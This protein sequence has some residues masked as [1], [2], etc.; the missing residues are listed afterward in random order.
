MQDNQS[1]ASF[2][3]FKIYLLTKALATEYSDEITKSLDQIPLV[4]KHIKENLLSD[5]KGEKMLHGKWQHSLIA[6][7]DNEIFAGVVIGSE[8]EK[9]NN[10]WYSKNSIYINDFAVSPKFQKLGLGKFLIKAWVAYN[11]SVGFV[12]L[13]E[14]LR[15]TVQTNSAEWNNHVHKIYESTGFKKF[16]TKPYDNRVDNVYILDYQK[17]K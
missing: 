6:V 14:E 2:K 16:A 11:K 5:F 10:I 12:E 8:R 3:Q 7:D 4:G 1:I 9:E 17:S 15:F 13:Q